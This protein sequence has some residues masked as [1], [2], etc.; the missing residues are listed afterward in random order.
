MTIPSALRRAD[1]AADD[2]AGI[3][4]ITGR[5][6][7]RRSSMTDFVI[8]RLKEP[9]TYAGLG[10]LLALFH[11]SIEPGLLQ[12]VATAGIGLAGAAAVAMK[13]RGK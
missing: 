4:T 12:A 8:S 5:D 2:I 10:V 9:T 1:L 7:R 13:E 11:V 6:A 3:M